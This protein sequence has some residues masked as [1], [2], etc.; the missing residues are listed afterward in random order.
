VPERVSV[1]KS[2]RIR[3]N[4]F[5]LFDFAFF[6]FLLA[7]L[8]LAA[9]NTEE[10]PA[11][12]DSI[13]VAADGAPELGSRAAVLMDAATGA[14]L[15][16]KN[17]D[18]LIPPASLTKLMTI[19]VALLEAAARNISL[20]ETVELPRQS[21]AINQPPR[22]SLMFLAA[23]QRVTIRELLL[24]LAVP[25]GND[26]AVAVALRFAPSVDAFARRMS[27]EARLLGLEKTLFVEPSGISEYNFTTAGE[28]ALFCRE[29]IALHPEALAEFH[30]VAEFAYPKPENVAERYRE[31]P[32]TIVQQN[33]NNLLD[34][35]F[36][37][38]QRPANAV[39]GVDGL[40]TGYIDEAGYNIALTA[41]RQGTRLIAVILGAPA[42]FRGERIRDKD[43][44][45]LLTWGF[46]NFKTLRPA[47]PGQDPLRVWKGKIDYVAC[48]PGEDLAFTTHANRGEGLYW[49]TEYADPLIAPLPV[50]SNVG[51]IILSDSRGD[52][53]RIPL[54]T[55]ENVEQGGFF[56]RL[57]DSIRVFFHAVFR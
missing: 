46:D 15:Y 47:F 24:G 14:V 2:L 44:K 52:L 16:A 29:Y 19:H 26:A 40:K 11:A 45:E 35:E 20:D 17:P 50:G 51:T 55:T 41:R 22:S 42:V 54:V 39:E 18:E 37:D 8:P 43:G 28:F 23:G 31:N 4:F 53:R 38:G 12:Q 57:F 27:A 33:R 10:A 9:Q 3:L 25:S 36:P 30:S 7:A 13:T 6:L 21:W 1:F 56:K 49:K 32:G 5:C 34:I 48:T